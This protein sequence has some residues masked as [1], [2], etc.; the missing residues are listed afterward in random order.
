MRNKLEY[1]GQYKL[2]EETKIKLT[3][4]IKNAIKAACAVDPKD[5]TYTSTDVMIS[6]W[7]DDALD[8]FEMLVAI[9]AFQNIQDNLGTE[10]TK[11]YL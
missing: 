8:D 6:L 11:R 4:S 1:P 5:D 10:Y 9:Q 3:S 2:G 7:N